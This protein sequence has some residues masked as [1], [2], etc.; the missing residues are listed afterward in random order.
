MIISVSVPRGSSASGK[1]H[2]TLKKKIGKY[3]VQAARTRTPAQRRS[4]AH[5]DRHRR[6]LTCQPASAVL[7][8][9][10]PMSNIRMICP[11]VV[12]PVAPSARLART[13][14]HSKPSPM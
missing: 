3:T 1:N 6:R 7:G 14:A 9:Q 5:S 8:S 13:H 12:P 2:A 10:P 4:L 11:A